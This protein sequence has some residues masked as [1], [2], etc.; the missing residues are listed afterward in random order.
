MKK[1]IILI[2]LVCFLFLFS[3]CIKK[4]GNTP[5]GITGMGS[6]YIEFKLDGTL[7]RIDES[8]NLL[9]TGA[10]SVSS[11]DDTSSST[12]K[13]YSA[14]YV[15]STVD[16]TQ[17]IMSATINVQDENSM[18]ITDY[19][20]CITGSA[21]MGFYVTLDFFDGRSNI[22]LPYD[23][24]ITGKLSMTNIGIVSGQKNEGTFHLE[25]FRI[26]QTNGQYS[27]ATHNLTEGK[28]SVTVD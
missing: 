10:S 9:T 2:A 4:K 19:N 26:L 28:F 6:D 20:A 23:S 1:Q 18:A 8:K 11:V 12:G 27:T 21:G 24:L 22:V 16:Q 3:S 5:N 13:K 17:D 15:F 14:A 7:Y 25:N